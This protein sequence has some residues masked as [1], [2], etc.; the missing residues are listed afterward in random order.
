MNINLESLSQMDAPQIKVTPPGPVSKEYLE[1]QRLH[2]GG[3]VSYPKGMPMAMR[4]ARGATIEDMDGNLYID[5]F[6]GA[7]VMAVGHNNPVVVQAVKEQLDNMTHTLDFPTPARRR[8]VEVL[9]ELLPTPLS[10]VSF[11]GPTGSDA[12]ESAIKLAKFNT[13]R[14]PVIAFEGAYHGMTAG[15]LSLCSGAQFKEDFL[16]LVPE[17]HFVP[18]AYCYRCPFNKS[19]DSCQLECAAYLEHILSD[20]HSG[21]TRPAAIIIEPIQGEGGSIVPPPE[22]MIKIREMCD[23]HEI[24]LIAD[25]IQ[26]GL[27]RTGKM[28]AFEHSGIIP[29]IVTMSKALGGIGLPISGIAYRESLNTWPAGKHI[30]TFRGNLL[31]YAAGAAALRF[32]IEQRLTEHVQKLGEEMLSWLKDLETNSKFVG[33]VRGKGLMLGI[34]FV[35]DKATKEPATDF[36]RKLRILAHQRGVMIEIGGHYSN[37]ARFLPPLVL[38]RELAKKGCEI[39]A[40][41]VHDIEKTL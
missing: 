41:S 28:F 26:C 11:G 3:I 13:K 21:V 9:N 20:P 29:D 36:A 37:V 8:L 39:I 25:E 2:E 18:Y 30:G 32:M 7:G 16:P 35:N 23:R 24:I 19:K 14:L 38:P 6:G 10:R 33:E 17:V 40:E 4:R 15:A 12:V 31:A 22:F 34:E 1:F 27:G 5:F